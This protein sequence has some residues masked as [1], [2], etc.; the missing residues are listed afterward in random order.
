MPLQRDLVLY[1]LKLRAAHRSNNSTLHLFIN[2]FNRYLLHAVCFLICR[3]YT[4]YV[5]VAPVL[6]GKVKIN[7][8]CIQD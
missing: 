4:P 6:V 2:S 5:H 8:E 7:N 1:K 3:R